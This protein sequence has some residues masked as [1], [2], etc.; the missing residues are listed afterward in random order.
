MVELQYHKDCYQLLEQDPIPS[1]ENE[2]LLRAIEL[3]LGITIPSSVREWYSFSNHA[4][5]L[6]NYSNTDHPI[7]LKKLGIPFERWLPYN[8]LD[9]NFLPFLIENQGVCTWAIHLDGQDNPPVYVEVDSG[10]PPVWQPCADSFSQWVFCLVH[11]KL[12]FNRASFGAQAEPLSKKDEVFLFTKFRIGLKT[13]SWPGNINYRLHG[14][15]GD[16]IIW[17]GSKQADWFL[18]P[19]PGGE[20]KLLTQLWACGN[21]A[22]SLY[23]FDSDAQQYL[24]QFRL[25]SG[26][27]AIHTTNE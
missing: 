27:A 3:D 14:Q 21:L 13:Y 18:A 24:Q 8:S 2:H 10:L 1:V 11:D 22:H 9:E 25:D 19:H 6:A 16:L 7:D 17:A 4:Q 23:G 5:I 26:I 15:Y 12:I 20:S